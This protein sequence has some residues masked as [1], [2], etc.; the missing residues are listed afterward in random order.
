MSSFIRWCVVLLAVMEC[1]EAAFPG[2][3]TIKELGN[4]G[5][6]LAEISKDEWICVVNTD[7][8]ISAWYLIRGSNEKSAELGRGLGGM[9]TIERIL[10]SP[11]KRFAA[12]CS[13]G[14][15]HPIIEIVDVPVLCQK[16]YKVIATIDPYP[17]VVWLVQWKDS[18]L[19][20]ASDMLLSMPKNKEGRVDSNLMLPKIM[21]FTL[22]PLSGGI[23][24]LGFDLKKVQRMFFAQLFLSR[25]DERD[26]AAMAL[27]ALQMKSSIP[28]LEKALR[29]ERDPNIVHTIQDAI[30][31]LK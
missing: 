18:H 27:K 5:V 19:M 24:P 20:I 30:A 7:E 15:G 6:A 25:P 17:G 9:T 23:S 1:W 29:K 22:D 12:V 4:R 11:D 3:L 28:Q 31:A 13:S 26:A 16:Q 8:G 10:I 21:K 14:E 2:D